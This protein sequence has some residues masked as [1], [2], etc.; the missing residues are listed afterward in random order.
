VNTR[1]N[2]VDARDVREDGVVTSARQAHLA[3]R[4]TSNAGWGYRVYPRGGAALS[5]RHEIFVSYRREVPRAAWWTRE[6]LLPTLRD[7]LTLDHG[8]AATDV[9]ADADLPS[10]ADWDRALRGALSH[11]KVLM[12]VL[13]ADYFQSAWCARELETFL[14]RAH[15]TGSRVVLPL[16]GRE[17]V[18]PGGA[19]AP[20][21]CL[22][23]VR[24]ARP[25]PAAAAGVDCGS[26]R[27][28]ERGC[29]ARE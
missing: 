24:G 11:T 1:A 7:F 5:Y 15:L 10:G 29:E 17:P 4:L 26:A 28:G 12:P 13:S 3:L 16:H 21:A 22:A 25:P 6:L 9:F 27:P 20:G 19:R 18:P 23:A 2:H 14:H 8:F